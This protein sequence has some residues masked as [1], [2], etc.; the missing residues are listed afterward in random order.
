MI[1]LTTKGNVFGGYTDIDW[2]GTGG[3]KSHNGNSFVFSM[4]DGQFRKFAYKK[5][6]Y[7]HEIDDSLRSTVGS[8]GSAIKFRQYF[9]KT[10][11]LKGYTNLG[12]NYEY[13]VEYYPS[14]KESEYYL[15]NGEW[16]FDVNEIEVFQVASK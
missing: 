12:F 15:N 3:L 8:F 9:K 1:I 4:R 11:Y 5:D 14:S 2:K 16:E 7:A 10:K 6:S 13:P